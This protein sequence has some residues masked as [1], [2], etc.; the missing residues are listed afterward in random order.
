[1]ITS[2]VT[3]PYKP[4]KSARPRA[5]PVAKLHL[6]LASVSPVLVS[7]NERLATSVKAALAVAMALRSAAV[8]ATDVLPSDSV[9]PAG[10]M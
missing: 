8:D 10:V 4:G 1:M 7:V 3:F 2:L 9:T 6:K 5:P